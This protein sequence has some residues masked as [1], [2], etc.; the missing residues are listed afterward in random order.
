MYRITFVVDAFKGSAD[1][2]RSHRILQLLL[3]ALTMANVEHLKADPSIPRIYQSGV[4]YE[5][6]PKGQEDWQDCLT[7]I[8]LH[9]GDCED[10]ACWRAA[11]LQVRDGIMAWPT[12]VWKIRPDGG[13]LYHI[14]VKY[15]DGRIEDPSRRLGM[16]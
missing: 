15:P 3:T 2:E 8:R 1:R 10:L 7:C 6:E 11:E 16:R 13:Y 14:Q 4:R 5:E 9:V 12:F